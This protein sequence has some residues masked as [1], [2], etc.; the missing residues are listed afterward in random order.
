MNSETRS[1]RSELRAEQARAT[2]DRILEATLRVMAR[3]L[4]SLSIPEVARE[5]GVSVPTVY[6]HFGSKDELLAAVYPHVARRVGLDTVPDPVT[7]DD[8]R[9]GVLAYYDRLANYSALDLAAVASPV[10]D[11]VRH[12]TM[13]HRLERLSRLADSVEP[14]LAKADRDRITRLLAVLTASASLRMWRDHLG[15]S[16]EE[17]ADDMVWVI[18]AVI[19]SVSSRDR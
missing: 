12:A 4:A 6:R 14:P 8:V 3:G 11:E 1:Y 19:A 15:S 13:A 7:L 2:R 9:A 16:V 17:A 18:S 10:G 5:A